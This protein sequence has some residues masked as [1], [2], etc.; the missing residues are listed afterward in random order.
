MVDCDETMESGGGGWQGS[1]LRAM[2]RDSGYQVSLQ[3]M[4]YTSINLNTTN[5]YSSSLYL[6]L[7]TTD[8]HTLFPRN[9]SVTVQFSYHHHLIQMNYRAK[10]RIR[11][12][13]ALKPYRRYTE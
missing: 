6:H 1:S 13:E 8:V 7:E 11:R 9:G 2:E 3:L 10:R 12:P 4:N 5:K